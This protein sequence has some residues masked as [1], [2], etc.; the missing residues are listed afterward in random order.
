MSNTS[1]LITVIGIVVF[2]IALFISAQTIKREPFPT[3]NRWLTGAWYA[4]YRATGAERLDNAI[5]RHY[6]PRR[7]AEL[8]ELLAILPDGPQFDQSRTR[9]AQAL[10]SVEER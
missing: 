2:D 6:A 8:R 5:A 9:L 4:V 1:A 7:A 3:I 10:A